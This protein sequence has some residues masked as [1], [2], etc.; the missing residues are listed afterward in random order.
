MIINLRQ[1]SVIMQYCQVFH[2]FYFEQGK[3]FKEAVKLVF[4]YNE[5]TMANDMV[6]L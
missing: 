5:E 1:T 6:E 3:I 4:L 2:K